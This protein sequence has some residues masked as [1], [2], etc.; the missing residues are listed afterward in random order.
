[1]YG[2]ADGFIK[3]PQYEISRKSFR[4]EAICFMWKAGHISRACYWYS[5]FN[6]G[7]KDI[8][9]FLQC[10]TCTAVSLLHNKRNEHHSVYKVSAGHVSQ[11]HSLRLIRNK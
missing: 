5:L 9:A 6:D 3:N 1:M 7:P 2:G 8:L 4:W 11:Q 10:S